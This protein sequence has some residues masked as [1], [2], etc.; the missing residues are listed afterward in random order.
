[1]VEVSHTGNT[2]HFLFHKNDLKLLWSGKGVHD[3]VVEKIKS[4]LPVYPVIW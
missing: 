2:Y 3:A 1:M 4:E